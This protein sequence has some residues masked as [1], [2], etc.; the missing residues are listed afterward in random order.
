MTTPPTTGNNRKGT[1]GRL[2]GKVA[3]ITGGTSGIGA[4]C[5]R[6]FVDEGARVVFTGRNRSKAD[7]VIATTGDKATFIEADVRKDDDCKSAVAATLE[8]HDRLDILFNNA[9]VVILGAIEATSDEDW[10]TTLATNV[11][12]VFQMCRAAVAHLRKG[13]GA[14]VNNASDWGIAGGQDAC[15][16]A[17]SK[18]A[19]VQLTRSLALDLARDGV[20]VNAVCPGDTYV[21]R[22]R[23]ESPEDVDEQ[24][25]AMAAVLPMGRVGHVD[26]IAEAVLFLASD[27][28]SYVT[29]QCLV[30]D[31]GNT[32]GDAST[33]FVG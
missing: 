2:V 29:G 25:Q 18:G 33:S 9:G 27:A 21:E 22:W 31:G 13:G 7:G 11:T 24:V 32:A 8:R 17:A 4:A 23:Q 10:A 20:R 30:V 14:I 15:A 3:L 12:G 5:V 28:S 26:E 1:G 16:Y 6:L 19:V